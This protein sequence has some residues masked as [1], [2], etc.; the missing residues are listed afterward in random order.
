MKIGILTYYRVANFG[1]NLQALSTYYYLKNHGHHP[2]FIHFMPADLYNWTNDASN[3]QKQ[4]HL[5]FIDSTLRDDQSKLI[6]SGD[7]MTAIIHE[8][9]LEGLIIGSDALLQHHPL[10]ERIKAG[11]RKPIWVQKVSSDR[12]FPNLFWGYG[13]PNDLPKAIMSVSSQNSKYKLFSPFVK[14]Q[15]KQSLSNFRYISVRDE[16]TKNLVKSVTN[17]DVDVT[18]DPVFAFNQ[19][20]KELLD[21]TPDVSQKFNLPG[22]YI[23]ISLGSQCLSMDQLKELKSQFASQGKS[24]VALPMPTGISFSHP[25]D[26]EIKCPLCP[27]DWYNLIRHSCGYIG[28][29]M[30]PIVVSLHNAVPCY[31]I[32]YWVNT[33]FW[34]KPVNDG[35]GKV[36]HI[37]NVF[38]VSSH[39]TIISNG[40]CMASVSEI[41]E[42]L[43]KFPVE[44]VAA[45]AADYYQQYLTMMATIEKSLNN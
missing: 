40:K 20:C 34:N 22:N 33:N 31:C 42:S 26:Y 21:T 41:V 4:A 8:Y 28:S 5:H 6:H 15:M 24:C 27:L 11:K 29:N 16:W 30:H 45:K 43:A 32:D 12:M 7:E 18:P 10:L 39:R 25:F 9:G 38:G 1:A 19:N 36:E 14:R 3:S 17:K 13:L 44:K 35:S 37:M 2:I 23:L